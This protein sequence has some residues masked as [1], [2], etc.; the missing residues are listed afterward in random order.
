MC[1]SWQKRKR[2]GLICLAIRHLPLRLRVSADPKILLLNIELELKSEKENAEV[3][4]DDPAKYQ[5]IVDAEWNIIY[6]KLAE[7]A[8]SGAQIV[9]SRWVYIRPSTGIAADV[10]IMM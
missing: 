5:S 1:S 9:L 6:G 8:N 4:L 3:R 10:K 2:L 7:C